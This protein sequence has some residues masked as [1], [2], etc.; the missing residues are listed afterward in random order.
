M[1]QF[2]L[3]FGYPGYLNIF[4]T[5]MAIMGMKKCAVLRRAKKIAQFSLKTCYH[6][7]LGGFRTEEKNVIFFLRRI[8]ALQISDGNNLIIEL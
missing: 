4:P 2:E 7:Y 1:G 8:F 5:I 3:F 6:I